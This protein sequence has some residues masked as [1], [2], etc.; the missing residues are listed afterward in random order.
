MISPEEA[1]RAAAEMKRRAAEDTEAREFGLRRD[2]GR[3]IDR[4]LSE[5][6]R[7][8]FF[9][10]DTLHPWEE[11]VFETYCGAWVVDV[12]R[13]QPS[14]SASSVLFVEFSP[15]ADQGGTK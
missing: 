11:Q 7:S 8:F 6:Q 4:A 13:E 5:G 10:R 2:Y 15:R 12:R 1:E 14:S 3:R 9:G